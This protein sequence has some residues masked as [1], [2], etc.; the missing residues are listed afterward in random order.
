MIKQLNKQQLNLV[1]G[2][3]FNEIQ[4]LAGVVSTNLEINLDDEYVVEDFKDLY[5]SLINL[6]LFSHLKEWD[7][8]V[9]ESCIKLM[10]RLNS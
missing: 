7:P 4:H 2:I 9:H 1:K 3:L 5:N 6:G 10:I 8:V